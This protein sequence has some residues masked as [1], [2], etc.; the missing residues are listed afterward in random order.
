[1]SS[2]NNA[3]LDKF[4]CET[5][6]LVEKLHSKFCKA[7]LLVHKKA[8]NIGVRAEL[9][10]Y[11]LCI[12][13]VSQIAKYF[14]NV[15]NKRQESIIKEAFLSQMGMLDIN[16]KRSWFSLLNFISKRTEWK[17]TCNKD[18]DYIPS[19]DIKRYLRNKYEGIVYN[20]LENEKKL[21]VLYSTKKSFGPSQY[22]SYVTNYKYRQAFTKMRISAHKFPIEVGRYRSVPR[23]ERLCNLCQNKEIGDELHYFIRCSDNYLNSIRQTFL[24]SIFANCVELQ[25]LPESCLFKYLM[26]GYDETVIRRTAQYVHDIMYYYVQTTSN[27]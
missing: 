8:S 21:H 19:V 18:N 10:R 1:M 23:N 17:V 7:T 22:L 26:S 14:V 15:C 9:G 27:T 3:T 5:N 24:N 6:S 4:L 16:Y 20:L 12:A 25:R 11:P 2:D 13:I